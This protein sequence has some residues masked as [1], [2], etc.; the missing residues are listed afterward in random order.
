[1]LMPNNFASCTRKCVLTISIFR[2]LLVHSV[3]SEPNDR[4]S[5]FLRS[6][7]SAKVR[8]D[9]F[10]HLST[11]KMKMSVGLVLA[12]MMDLGA[13]SLLSATGVFLN[14]LD[15]PVSVKTHVVFREHNHLHP[16]KS[17]PK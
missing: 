6:C 9:A 16:I 12:A 1:M 17:K 7:N 11:E 13:I 15:E 5:M 2:L 4:E 3:T 10:V 14:V 8:A